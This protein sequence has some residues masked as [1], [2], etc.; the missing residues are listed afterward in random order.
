MKKRIFAVLLVGIL[1]WAGS[2][3]ATMI[4]FDHKIDNWGPLGLG[5]ALITQAKPLTY[6]HNINSQ[7]N[8]LAGDRVTS[9]TLELDFTNDLTDSYGNIGKFSGFKWDFREF[10]KVGW[11]GSAWHDLGEVDNG[12]YS[13]LVDIDWLNVDGLLDV[14]LKVSNPLGTA[15]AWLDHSRLYGTA[16]AAPVPEPGTLLL[17]GSG[18]A[19]LALYRRKK[20]AK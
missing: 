6:T 1:A 12:Q 20:A 17:L 13:L 16:E 11:D 7:V 19:G 9:A 3:G 10:A 8:F 15:T 14:T 4:N 18:L 5:S 2:A